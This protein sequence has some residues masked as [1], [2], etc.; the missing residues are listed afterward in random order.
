METIANVVELLDL[1]KIEENI[2]RGQNYKTPWGRVFGG[3]VL[4]QA[5]HAAYE[6]VPEDRFVHSLHGYFILV[7]DVDVPIVYEV[8]RIRDGGS[9]TTRRVVAIQK[10]R[11]IFNLS[12]SFQVHKP[13]L[14]HQ[15]PMPNVPS[16]ESLMS[17]EEL[18]ESLRKRPRPIEY[19]PVEK[20]RTDPPR[21]MPPYQNIWLKAK[22]RLPD[23]LRTHQE[24]LTFT[25]DFHLL[26]TS[27]LP[28]QGDT[29]KFFMVSLD[30]AMWFH[31]DFRMDDWLLYSMDSPSASNERG[32][33]RGSLFNQDGDLVASVVQ[34]GLMRVFKDE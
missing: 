34:E 29:P 23:N 7:G 17:D 3:Q 20:V 32:F 8:D 25:V 15:I 6:T 9:F 22:G 28:H 16:P 31:R 1:E 33:N 14:E 12:A 4:A 26:G 24:L 13:G 21:N 18:N 30:H 27:T 11:P 19:R 5:L 10:G 2:F